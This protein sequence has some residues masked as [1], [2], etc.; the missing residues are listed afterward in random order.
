MKLSEIGYAS[1]VKDF[2]NSEFTNY[3]APKP[4]FNNIPT[5]V[6]ENSYFTGSFNVEPN[7][8]YEIWCDKGTI[9]NINITKGTFLY[10]AF[11]ITDK[12]D[13]T[14][15]IHIKSSKSGFLASDVTNITVN[16]IYVPMVADDAL[17]NNDFK[18]NMS[19]DVEPDGFKFI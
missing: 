1:T 7:A 17:I 10:K 13:S 15:V 9:S 11:D 6:N 5:S 8:T 3:K 12:T 4:V 19:P 14:D 16:V 2:I 18:A